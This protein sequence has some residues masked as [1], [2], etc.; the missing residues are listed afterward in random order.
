MAKNFSR[1]EGNFFVI[2]EKKNHLPVTRLGI[3]VTRRFGDAHR[4][5]RLKRLAREAFRLCY[6]DLRKGIDINLRPRE[7]ALEVTLPQIQEELRKF[8]LNL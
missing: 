1:H 8:F 3:T 6:V 7:R 2:D 4:R 5:N